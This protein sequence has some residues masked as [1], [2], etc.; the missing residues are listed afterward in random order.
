M[1]IPFFRIKVDDSKIKQLVKRLN[2]E[3]D[4]KLSKV[5]KE[6]GRVVHN[7][8]EDNF[9]KQGR[10]RWPK[11]AKATIEERKEKGYVPIH[12]LQRTGF[13]RGRIKV[14]IP[15]NV[16]N[17][18]VQTPKVPYARIHQFGGKAGYKRKVKIPPR[19]FLKLTEE[20][21]KEMENVLKRFLD[22]L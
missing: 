11:L 17:I 15:E 3:T 8:I 7:S 21:K 1:A 10:P 16:S 6:I 22:N 2:R 14:S 4:S 5:R 18:E 19:P 9:E 20:D 13:L 12:I